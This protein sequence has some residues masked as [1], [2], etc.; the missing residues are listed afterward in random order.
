MTDIKFLAEYTSEELAAFTDEQMA[1][2]IDLEC[3]E[4]GVPLLP[5]EP[6]EPESLNV[7]PDGMVYEIGGI[8]FANHEDAQSIYELIC[9]MK[10]VETHYTT[11]VITLLKK[12]HY[13]EPKITQKTAWT[14]GGYAVHGTK[15]EAN[16]ILW[17]EYN[18]LMADYQDAVKQ[19]ADIQKLVWDACF[20]ARQQ[21]YD[22]QKMIRE[23]SSYLELAQGQREIALAFFEKRYPGKS[24]VLTDVA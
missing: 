11:N 6:V 10:L 3:A 21:I 12:G 9:S 23:F 7:T 16:S 24:D 15:I 17:D 8:T 2:L 18:G 19:R 14:P 4:R 20:E 22:Q 5:L 1:A 13:N